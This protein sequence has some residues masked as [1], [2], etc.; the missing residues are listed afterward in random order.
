V[1]I[2]HPII[3]RKSYSIVRNSV[4]S[5]VRDFETVRNSL[6][7]YRNNGEEEE[8]R[9]CLFNS[10]TCSVEEIAKFHNRYWP[11]QVAIT[12]DKV[13]SYVRYLK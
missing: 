8:G 5:Q 3:R 13:N 7:L 4:E 10:Y 1:E 9:I 11:Y 2:I 12:Q 6:V